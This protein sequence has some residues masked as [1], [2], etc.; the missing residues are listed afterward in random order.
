MPEVSKQRVPFDEMCKCV[1]AM[2]AA[3]G[4]SEG[5]ARITADNLVKADLRGVFSHGVMR[6]PIYVKRLQLKVTN[7]A[8]SPKVIRDEKATA[9][10][11]GDNAMGQVAGK[12]AMDIAAEKAKQF[13]VGVVAVKGS[14]HYGASVH[15]AQ[16]VLAEDMIGITGTIGGTNIMAPWGGTDRRLGNNPFSV[17]V[18]ALH[19]DPLV[20][21]MAN[22]VVARGKIVL[23]AKTKQPIPQEWALSPDGSPTT[24]PVEAYHGTV[25]P[26]GGY[27]GYGLTLM[28]GLLSSLLSGAL[29]GEKITDLYEEFTTPQDLGH[30]MQAINIASFTDPV[31]LRS[32]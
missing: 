10:V 4:M 11:D 5:D 31:R 20:L 27:K 9:V 17:A 28:T 12:F 18:P 21:D 32:M 22:S 13:G 15:F 7:P 3:V 14:N 24:D 1:Q 29:F 23:A 6:V 25:Q 26:I 2:F 19:K 16:M 30:Y 8:G